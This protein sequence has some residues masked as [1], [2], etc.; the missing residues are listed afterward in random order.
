MS[1]DTGWH[2]ELVLTQLRSFAG[3][4]R[5][6]TAT[7]DLRALQ[8]IEHAFTAE[9]GLATPDLTL[10]IAWHLHVDGE[11]AATSISADLNPVFAFQVTPVELLPTPPPNVSG[12]NGPGVS[13]AK[14]G[15]VAVRTLTDRTFEV[16]RVQL[17]DP[18][19]RLLSIMLVAVILASTGAVVALDRRR[20]SRG[21]AA[22]IIGRYRHLLVNADTIPIADRRPTVAVD[23]MRDLVRLAKLHE[24]FIVHAEAGADHRFAVFTDAVVYVHDIGPVT[25]S[26]STDDTLAQW[27]LAGLEAC[28]AERRTAACAAP[29]RPLVTTR[30]SGAS[31]VDGRVARN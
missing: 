8:R 14:T 1:S 30:H 26:V 20:S 22:T 11:V 28:A 2:R 13:V 5:H 10:Q 15:S 27:A 29:T 25:R 17:S 3:D 6:A 16:W 19:T 9:T 31:M 18:L 4:Q 24:E 7:L 21:A 23:K 12:Q